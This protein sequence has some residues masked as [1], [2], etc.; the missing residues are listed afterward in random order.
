MLITKEQIVRNFGTGR[1]YVR[2]REEMI[3][4]IRMLLAAETGQ[5][6]EKK[7]EK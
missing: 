5:R 7:R 6:K 3:I 1:R 4:L 2:T